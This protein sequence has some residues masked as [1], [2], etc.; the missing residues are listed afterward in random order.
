MR[1]PFT[2]KKFTLAYQS[3]SDVFLFFFRNLLGEK[4]KII[5]LRS[6]QFLRSGA[7]ASP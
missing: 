5:P 7:L 4:Q 1:Q 2:V 6:A 3:F